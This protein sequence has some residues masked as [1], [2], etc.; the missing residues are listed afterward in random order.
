MEGNE[1]FIL[2]TDTVGSYF[3]VVDDAYDSKDFVKMVG[4]AGTMALCRF[5]RVFYLA[6]AARHE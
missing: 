5:F 2:N 6:N 4:E 3:S 1:L